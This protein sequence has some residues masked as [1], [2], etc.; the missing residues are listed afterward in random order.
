MGLGWLLWTCISVSV[1]AAWMPGSGLQQ[2]ERCNKAPV[3]WP[4]T[5]RKVK[6]GMG[7]R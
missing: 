1:C 5:G 7:A 4:V 6:H 3:K 2:R